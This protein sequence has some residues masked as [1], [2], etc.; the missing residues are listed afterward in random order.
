MLTFK[1]KLC[2]G[3]EKAMP[4]PI[5]VVY[6]SE[7]GVPADDMTV[8]FPYVGA[9]VDKTDFIY[10][11]DGEK[12]VFAGQADEIITSKSADG[13]ITKITARSMA[14]FLL[15]NEAVPCIYHNPAPSMIYEKHLLPYGFEN[16]A[17]DDEPFFGTLKVTKGMSEWQ[18]LD[19]F[20]RN[21][22]SNSARITG[23]GRVIFKKDNSSDKLCFS[24]KSENGYISLKKNIRRYKV[25]SEVR[26]RLTEEGKYTSSVKNDF[27]D[28]K[29][30]RRRLVNAL[31][32]TNS[33]DTADRMIAQSNSEYFEITLECPNRYFD[34]T[35]RSTE[36][37]DSRFGRIDGL[38]VHS[39]KYSLG[40]GGEITTVTVRKES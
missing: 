25:I 37:R 33:V 21:K 2:D 23:D 5:T 31:A 14:A 38:Y 8:T 6:N 28:K 9:H 27:E 18:V 34:I 29:I 4:D 39:L 12:K 11:F 19:N 3:R 22:H 10:A 36:I 35:G 20:C 1:I 26:L 30:I 15:D 17:I 32:D 7:F 13:I 24:D 40:S 16:C